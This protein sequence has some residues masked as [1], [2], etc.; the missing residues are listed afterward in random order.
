MERKKTRTLQIGS[1]KI[2]GG[3]EIA[4]QSMLC[5]P[6]ADVEANV[7][8]AKRLF[9][10]GCDIIRVAVPDRESVRLIGAIKAAVPTP[11]V[12]DIHFDHR[13]ALAAVEAGVDK[14]RIN[15]GNIGGRERVQAVADACK[16][17]GVPIRIGV[18]GGSLEKEILQKYGAPPPPPLVES[19]LYHISLLEECGFADIAIS[20][21]SSSV[22]TMI[23]AYRLMSQRCDYPLHL[24]V[25]EAGTERM[26]LIKSAVGIGSLLCDGIGDTIRVSL[27]DDPVK[28]VRAARDILKALGIGKQGV[29]VVSCPTCGRTQ[30]DLI[31]LAKEV[32][33][34]VEGMEKDI[35]V[36]VMGCAVNGPGEAREADIGVAGGDGCGLLFRKGEI[37]RKVPEDQILP[38]LME[39]IERL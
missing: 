3:E 26:G 6:A 16:A 27:T 30:I 14:V 28:E 35:T 18:N 10:A 34:L 2:G 25:T 15:P 17:H 12:A 7:E 39:E 23:E 32:D 11:L 20:L 1:V 22:P 29:R 37:L 33:R 36:A 4:V 19:A 13:L 24:G 31:S 21:K 5:A 8:Q 38:A 9:A